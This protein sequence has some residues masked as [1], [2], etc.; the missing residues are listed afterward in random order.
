M[1]KCRE[2]GMTTMSGNKAIDYSDDGYDPRRDVLMHPDDEMAS[3][4][5]Y[6]RLGNIS[7]GHIFCAVIRPDT[8][9]RPE[10]VTIPMRAPRSP[11]SS[12]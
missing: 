2:I 9:T 3:P 12:R 10:Y 4:E 6:P 1:P 8:S 5:W 7:A 11:R